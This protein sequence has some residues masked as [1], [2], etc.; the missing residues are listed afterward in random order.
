M[1]ARSGLSSGAIARSV[2][3]TPSRSVIVRRREALDISCEAKA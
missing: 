2:T 3:R 1:A